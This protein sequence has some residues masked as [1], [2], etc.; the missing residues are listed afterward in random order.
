MT[1]ER[2]NSHDRRKRR[3]HR[4]SRR[5]CRNCKLRRVKVRT[6]TSRLIY[7]LQLDIKERIIADITS[8]KCD[9]AR[10][11]CKKCSNFG[12]SCNYDDPN[13]PDLQT[14]CHSVTLGSPVIG[15]PPKSASSSMES[16]FSVAKM[17]V[18]N[19]LR[20]G[21]PCLSDDGKSTILLDIECQG[22]LDRFISRTVLTVGT[23]HV[24]VI[25]Q[26]EINSIICGVC[27]CHDTA[28]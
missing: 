22:R 7:L 28:H 10:P 15:L 17:E 5:G 11:G 2:E 6:H 26:T 8:Y 24:S 12:V 25:F 21:L 16:C 9:E 4:K 3:T 19:S 13:A 18:L 20:P 23:P 14:I 27:S 1:V